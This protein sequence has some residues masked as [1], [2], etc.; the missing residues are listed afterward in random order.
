[1]SC[2][3]CRKERKPITWE[4]CPYCGGRIKKTIDNFPSIEVVSEL[5]EISQIYTKSAIENI[6]NAIKKEYKK[7]IS[8]KDVCFIP[9][10]GGSKKA[11]Y[12]RTL[13]LFSQIYND[14]GIYYA[15]AFLYDSQY[16]RVDIKRM[17]EILKPRKII[18]NKLKKDLTSL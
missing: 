4:F 10:I 2:K 14:Q 8:K 17:M 5:R 18:Q 13:E 9:G 1:M 7:D 12:L 16:D 15:F 6:Y 3:E 11:E